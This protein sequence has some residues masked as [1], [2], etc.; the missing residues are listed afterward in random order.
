[1]A[2]QSPMTSRPVPP[3][4]TKSPR[5]T[6][7]F[8]CWGTPRHTAT[9]P[10]A[11]SSRLPRQSSAPRLNAI[12]EASAGAQQQ[13]EG[14]GGSDHSIQLG[15]CLREGGVDAET[16]FSLLKIRATDGKPP[17]RRSASMRACDRHRSVRAAG[18][19]SLQT[20]LHLCVC[21]PHLQLWVNSRTEPVGLPVSPLLF[22]GGSAASRPL[23]C[24]HSRLIRFPPKTRRWGG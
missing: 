2:T 18:I 23:L 3:R 5:M 11:T 24:P 8:E 15:I 20:L 10:P 4:P 7:E 17:M 13:R 16:G 22:P 19:K 21:A 1:M 12:T 14:G 9:T 6:N